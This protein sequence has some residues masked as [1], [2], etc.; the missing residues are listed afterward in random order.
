MPDVRLLHYFEPTQCRS[1]SGLDDGKR[2]TKRGWSPGDSLNLVRV[3]SVR[4]NYSQ[5]CRNDINGRWEYSKSIMT[6]F[7]LFGIMPIFLA[8]HFSHN[9]IYEDGEEVYIQHGISWTRYWILIAF[10][11]CR[12]TTRNEHMNYLPN[13]MDKFMQTLQ[14]LDPPF[15]I[16]QP[17]FEEHFDKLEERSTHSAFCIVW[18]H[19]RLW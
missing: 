2:K 5:Q 17:W 14:P 11:F 16:P 9:D 6:N 10:H 7:N 19:I 8:N 3:L 4:V 15:R 12:L 13:N 1:V 18:A